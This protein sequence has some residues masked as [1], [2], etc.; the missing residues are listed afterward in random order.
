MPVQIQFDSNV[1]WVLL[2]CLKAGLIARCELLYGQSFPEELLRL[3]GYRSETPFVESSHLGLLFGS[4]VE[5]QVQPRALSIERA[6]FEDKKHR[7]AWLPNHRPA[8]TGNKCRLSTLGAD[9]ERADLETVECYLSF[10][11]A[12]EKK[13]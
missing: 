6:R 3:P 10:I 7:I 13:P 12:K 5:Y 9:H 1:W 4:Y 2:G 8:L 11:I